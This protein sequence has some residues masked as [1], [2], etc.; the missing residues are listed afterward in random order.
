ME[1]IINMIPKASLDVSTLDAQALILPMYRAARARQWAV[2]QCEARVEAAKDAAAKA[3]AE[4][5]YANAGSRDLYGPVRAAELSLAEQVR[6]FENYAGALW[7]SVVSA[8]Q[9]QTQLEWDED[10]NAV[11]VTV[12]GQALASH[13]AIQKFEAEG[14]WPFRLDFSDRSKDDRP[15]PL[16]SPEVDWEYVGAKAADSARKL[17]VQAIVELSSTGKMPWRSDQRMSDDACLMACDAQLVRAGQD[18]WT[19]LVRYLRSNALPYGVSESAFR[20]A[21]ADLSAK[22]VK[23]HAQDRLCLLAERKIHREVD[24]AVAEADKAELTEV[25][26]QVTSEGLTWKQ[27]KKLAKKDQLVARVL[28]SKG[29]KAVKKACV[30]EPTSI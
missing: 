14:A 25:L 24:K 15:E 28:E 1:K 21:V 13:W 17:I 4:N 10:G 8:R 19:A 7:A 11:E 2:S 20:Q 12:H 16:T 6:Q 26:D 23:E 22:S 27:V 9:P 30:E 5:A 29:R 3:L 18:G